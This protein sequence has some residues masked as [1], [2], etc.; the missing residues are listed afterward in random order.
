MNNLI[1]P[2]EIRCKRGLA[3]LAVSLALLIVGVP[4]ALAAPGDVDS[5]FGTDGLVQ[6]DLGASFESIQFDA[7][8]AEAE[9]RFLVTREKVGGGGGP[10]TVRRFEPDGAVDPSFP[11]K[12]PATQPRAVQQDSKVLVVEADSGRQLTRLN[13]DGT[14]DTTF[15]P[16]GHS[17][18][19]S[20]PIQF[21][22]P[23]PSGKI[24]VAGLA[25]NN[26][27]PNDEV[28]VARFQ[29]DG[30]LDPGFGTGG[31]ANLKTAYGIK[32]GSLLG[33]APRANEG[34]VVIVGSSFP[35]VGPSHSI[36]VGLA[37]DGTLDP[38][39]GEAGQVEPVGSVTA[40]QAL[41]DGRLVVAGNSWGKHFGC[42]GYE[43]AM[44]AARYNADGKPDPSFGDGSG[45]IEAV[46]DGIDRTASLLVGSDGSVL[47]GGSSTASTP[48]CTTFY[49]CR[50]MPIVV[51]FTAA[52]AADR[53]FADKGVL[54]L[55]TLAGSGTP[56]GGTFTPEG[57]VSFLSRP[58][59]GVIAAGG[60]GTAAF[61]A[62]IDPSGALDPSFGNGGIVTEQEPKPSSSSAVAT[63]I[64]PDGRILVMADSSAASRDL[65]PGGNVLLRYRRNG[66]LD[67]SFGGGAG[68]VPV[69][70]GGSSTVPWA[71]GLAVDPA[72]RGLVL[73][74]QS[75]ARVTA[76]GQLDK[77]FG[78]EG[79]VSLGSGTGRGLEL[80]AIAAAPRGRVLVAG[81]IPHGNG[82]KEQMV[83]IRLRPNGSYDPS[84]AGDGIAVPGFGKRR[85]SG[86]SRLVV[87]GRGRILLAG[88]VGGKHS[89]GRTAE[90]T[91]LVRLRPNGS[92]DRSFGRNG[93]VVSRSGGPSLV[94]GLAL[95]NGRPLV[96]A[97]QPTGGELLLRFRP[98][99]RRDPSFGR[100]G[101]VRTAFEPAAGKHSMF[102]ETLT[103]LPTKRRLITVR[104]GSGRPIRA[105]RLDGRPDPAYGSDPAIAA[106][107][108]TRDGAPTPVA[109]LQNGLPVLAWT[110]QRT[111]PEGTGSLMI[112]LQRLTG[113]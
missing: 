61:L 37:G 28:S 102:A 88:Y 21:I 1:P 63:A 14:P 110:S 92:L 81:V 60:V 24:L 71:Q 23:L 40:F 43:S 89:E 26:P 77:G 87:D 84:F 29:A 107:R 32:A 41:D 67:H 56:Y 75:V 10:A 78:Q 44:F 54:R 38:T 51:R 76:S 19:T 80:K 90:P 45:T 83:V 106:G 74:T 59:G 69:P 111:N 5:S 72:G 49:V 99:G 7:L 33:I 36:L 113:Q 6:T 47:L 8:T 16:G 97:L 57:V 35:Q 52:G 48:I 20:L 70:Y 109:A 3:A 31:I 50:T 103:P 100:N 108:I 53:G 85:P 15:G 9:G 96:A 2:N 93:R 66:A 13:P 55:E 30:K 34:A 11:P 22:L 68:Y 42:C 94:T 58:D 65:G 95:Q 82:T 27:G 64:A 101:T 104:S 18:Q 4:S 12:P 62:G 25:T 17:E 91:A 46:S 79:A 39:Y 73:G 86:V 98:D 112:N 105:F